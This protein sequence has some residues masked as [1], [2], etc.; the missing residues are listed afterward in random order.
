MTLM[1]TQNRNLEVKRL[2]AWCIFPALLW[3]I[4]LLAGPSR[5]AAGSAWPAPPGGERR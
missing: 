5:V 3:S 4:F 2:L 1:S